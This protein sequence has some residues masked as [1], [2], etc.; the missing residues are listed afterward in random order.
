MPFLGVLAD[1]ENELQIGESREHWLAP[2]FGAFTTWREIA[3]FG[4]KARE[5]EAHG[6]D[7]DDP[8]IVENA[9][10]DAEPAP[11]PDA[12]WVGIGSTRGMDSNPR[13]L[14]GDANARGGRNLKDGPWLMREGRAISRGVTANAACADVSGKR[15]K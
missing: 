3:A 15:R 7:G 1:E 5:T 10:T 4:V 2:Q 8:R 11:Q 13:R 9:L 14:A 6:H 12:G